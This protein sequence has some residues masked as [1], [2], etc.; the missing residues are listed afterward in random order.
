MY[1]REIYGLIMVGMMLLMTG[2]SADEVVMETTSG[3]AVAISFNCDYDDKEENTTRAGY[4]GTM[5]TEDLQ[6]TGFGAM[7]SLS[8]GGAPTYDN[9][10]NLMYNQE[11]EFTLVGDLENPKKGYWSYQPVKY[12]PSDLEH[13]YISAYAPY[14]EPADLVG[15]DETKTG[16][17]GMSENSEAPYIAYRRCETP[18]SNVDLLWYYKDFAPTDKIPEATAAQPAGTLNMKMRHALARLEIQVALATDVVLDAGT[19][20]LIEKITLTGN[21]AKTGRLHLYEQETETVV[22][23]EEEVTKY[24]P[25]WSDQTYDDHT[26]QITNLD[27]DDGSYG[28]IDNQIRYIEGL[29]YS[30]QPAG[31]QVYNPSAPE[32]TD[33]GMRNALSTG[34]RTGYVYLIPQDVQNLTVK[35]KYHKMTAEGDETGV[36]TTTESTLRIPKPTLEKPNPKLRGN[37]TYTLKLKLSS[38]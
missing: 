37:A 10:P 32:G 19:K 22:V 21:M 16:I 1:A 6:T 33:D 12:W 31:L 8:A 17:I 4:E 26:F 14:V 7:A 23:N 20:V 34:D 28:I 24:Y 9:K 18:A 15:L 2:C 35:V 5:N 13:C 29:P 30:W 3:E 11:V 25:V 36:R 38:I 27:N